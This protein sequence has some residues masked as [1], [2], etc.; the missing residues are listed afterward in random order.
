MCPAIPV[1]GYSAPAK[2]GAGIGVPVKLSAIHD[3]PSV[4]F[5]SLAQYTLFQRFGVIPYLHQN[6]G[7][8]GGG[9]YGSAGFR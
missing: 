7:G 9:F 6:Y 5:V 3:A 8:L 1:Y 4:F 2:S